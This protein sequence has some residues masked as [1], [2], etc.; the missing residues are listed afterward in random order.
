MGMFMEYIYQLTKTLAL[1]YEWN[2]GPMPSGY[3]QVRLRLQPKPPED[4]T[5]QMIT[6]PGRIWTVR[7]T[8]YAT[9]R[10]PCKVKQ[11]VESFLPTIIEGVYEG[12]EYALA[13]H[14]DHPVVNVAVVLERVTVDLIYSTK[15]AFKIAA[16]SAVEQLLEQAVS[17]N[18]LIIRTVRRQI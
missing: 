16:K 6:A 12:A 13:H 8:E 5:I 14:L 7:V 2:K 10:D 17:E 4:D 18:L 9:K 15:V 11:N 3:A 1:E